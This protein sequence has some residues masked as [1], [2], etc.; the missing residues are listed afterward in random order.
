MTCRSHSVPLALGSHHHHCFSPEELPKGEIPTHL[1]G[2]SIKWERYLPVQLVAQLERLKPSK[3]KRRQQEARCPTLELQ[4]LH[5]A[6]PNERS[7]SPWTYRIDEDSNRYPQ[8]LAFAECLCTGCINVK[9]G[10]ETSSLNSVPLH[11]TMMVLRRRPCV[12]GALR[13]AASPVGFTFN[14]EYIQVPVGCTCVLPR[15]SG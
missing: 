1:L 13:T 2:R 11:Q 6:E 3:R 5:Q 10:Q 14:V 9:T 7:I 12:P 15:S 8:K 4:S